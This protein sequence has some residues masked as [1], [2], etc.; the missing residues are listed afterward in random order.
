MVPS[1]PSSI[2]FTPNAS[3]VLP[4]PGS[5]HPHWHDLV[6][7]MNVYIIGSKYACVKRCCHALPMLIDLTY[8][9]LPSSRIS[10]SCLLAS[11][12]RVTM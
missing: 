3:S 1:A 10:G 11:T 2:A 8:I 12:R 6:R 4:P 5:L 7:A 9:V